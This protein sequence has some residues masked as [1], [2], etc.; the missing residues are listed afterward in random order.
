MEGGQALHVYGALPFDSAPA[1]F[2]RNKE[3]AHLF[4]QDRARLMATTRKLGVRVIVVDHNG[5][6]GQHTPSEDLLRY[7]APWLSP[8][9]FRRDR[10][11]LIVDEE[12]AA[13]S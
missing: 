4:D 1:V 12:N 6:R 9:V 2:K 7:T 10:R 8:E 5:R 3:W 13:L 11:A